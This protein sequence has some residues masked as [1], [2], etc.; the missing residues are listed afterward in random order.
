MLLCSTKFEGNKFYSASQRPN[1]EGKKN[2]TP[3]IFQIKIVV[4]CDISLRHNRNFDLFVWKLWKSTCTQYKNLTKRVYRFY[5]GAKSQFTKNRA[6]EYGGTHSNERSLPATPHDTW[7]G[8]WIY[9]LTF[10]FAHY[11]LICFQFSVSLH[12][13]HIFIISFLWQWT[14]LFCY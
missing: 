11:L 5:S 7:T 8:Y 14:S 9:L 10:R 12:H 1:K 2:N 3:T 6:A 4:T 13:I